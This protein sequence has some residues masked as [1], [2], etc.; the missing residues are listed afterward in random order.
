MKMIDFEK[1][2][3]ESLAEF[4]EKIKEKLEN[5]AICI[6]EDSRDGNLLG[7]YEGVPK[8]EWGRGFTGQL[9]DKITLFKNPILREGK[10]SEKVKETIKLTIYHEIAHYFGFNEK[11]TKQLEKLFYERNRNNKQGGNY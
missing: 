11:E 5:V 7:L 10:D 2:V 1:L 6:E 3:E 9:P 8:N 4:P